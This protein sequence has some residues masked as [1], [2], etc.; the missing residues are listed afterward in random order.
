MFSSVQRE[1]VAFRLHRLVQSMSSR[2]ERG[3]SDE[4]SSLIFRISVVIPELF[5][6]TALQAG[7]IATSGEFWRIYSH[8]LFWSSP[9]Y[10]GQNNIYVFIS[11]F[12]L[13]QVVGKKF[14]R[15]LEEKTHIFIFFLFFFYLCK[16]ALFQNFCFC[17]QRCTALFWPDVSLSR[18]RK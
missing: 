9:G 11:E 12:Q 2:S 15:L 16:F 10:Y 6:I 14:Q 7:N 3:Q 13:Q 4:S 18:K 5:Y 17:A 1:T 8:R